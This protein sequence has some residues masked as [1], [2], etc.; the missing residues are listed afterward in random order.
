MPI[1]IAIGTSSL[2]VMATSLSGLLGHITGGTFN[3]LAALPLA[4][5]AFVGGR[6]GSSFSL[7][8]KAPNLKIVFTVMLLLTA[9]WMIISIFVQP[10]G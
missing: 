2:M 4:G 10:A 3:V 6:I 7:R 5:A 9:A 1:R 8:V